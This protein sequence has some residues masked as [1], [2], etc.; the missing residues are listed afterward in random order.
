MP[1]V[2]SCLAGLPILRSMLF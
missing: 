1:S 2:R